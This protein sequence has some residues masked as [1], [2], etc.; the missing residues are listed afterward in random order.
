MKKRLLTL[1]L[2]TLQACSSLAPSTPETIQSVTFGSSAGTGLYTSFAIHRDL[3][4]EVSHAMYGEK[5]IHTK[6]GD[7]TQA[8]FNDL[9]NDLE[10]AD[11]TQKR[12]EFKPWK[13]WS[14][15]AGSSS[16]SIQTDKQAYVFHEYG[17]TAFSPEIRELH[18]KW[19]AYNPLQTTSWEELQAKENK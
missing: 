9:V 3:S 10:K 1:S 16:I 11:Y 14:Q 2:L 7:I 13:A 6:T 17:S 19:S 4:T 18:T 15:G 5:E 12:H 8:Q